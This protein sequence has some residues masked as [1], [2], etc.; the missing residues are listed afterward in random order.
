MS[1]HTFLKAPSLPE[2]ASDWENQSHS[3]K[4]TRQVTEPKI[5]IK[6]AC[7]ALAIIMAER[8]LPLTPFA[9]L[10]VCKSRDLD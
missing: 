10:Y 7:T 4:S 6:C 9:C 3:L 1:C 5:Q 8:R 2:G